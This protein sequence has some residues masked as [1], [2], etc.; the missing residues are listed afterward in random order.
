MRTSN[1]IALL[2]LLFFIVGIIGAYT[3]PSIPSNSIDKNY[4]LY[5]GLKLFF[6]CMFL[7]IYPLVFI[8]AERFN[9]KEIQEEIHIDG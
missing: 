1:K 8:V 5:L 3:S 9:H 7:S 6:V 4:N 2:G